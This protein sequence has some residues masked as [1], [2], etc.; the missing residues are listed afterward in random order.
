[1][2]QFSISDIKDILGLVQFKEHTFHVGEMGN[3]FYLQVQYMDTDV[4]TG[5][6]EKQ[7]GRK[8]YVSRFATRS[9][10][11]QTAFKAVLTSQ[12]HIAREFFLY[13]GK[14][15]FGPHYDVDK[16]VGLCSDDEHLDVRN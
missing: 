3:G 1:M 9:E 11:V 7:H 13:K 16:L 14:R 5:K 4:D 2:S 12:E 15:I 8:W 10:I 6:E